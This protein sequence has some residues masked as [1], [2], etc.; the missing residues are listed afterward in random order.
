[1]LNPQ[2]ITVRQAAVIVFLLLVAG[3]VTAIFSHHW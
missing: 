1:M 3:A 2:N